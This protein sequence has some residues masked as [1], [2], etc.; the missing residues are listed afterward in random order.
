VNILLLKQRNDL[1]F[2]ADP[3]LH[4]FG[5]GYCTPGSAGG[6]ISL[7]S[8]RL[9]ATRGSAAQRIA[10]QYKGMKSMTSTDTTIE[11]KYC[12]KCGE[13]KPLPKFKLRKGL[14]GPIC[15]VCFKSQR[16]EEG[17]ERDKERDK[18]RAPETRQRRRRWGEHN[19]DKIASYR[20]VRK[21]REKAG[22]NLLCNWFGNQCLAC[23]AKGKLVPDH[24]RPLVL[25]G[26]HDLIN[27]QPLC[28]D[29]NRR[30]GRKRI[31]Y[32][33]RES[34]QAFINHLLAEM[35]L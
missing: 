23:G 17:K 15:S 18:E 30:K 6:I 2:S 13:W 16:S 33:D 31:D 12:R 19:Q 11:G 4:L 21:E 27:L 8:K 10:R 28:E 1:V 7:Q 20:L 3:W 22:W 29:C 14:R 26:I 32:R 5:V 24:V 9:S 34:L 35:L 25:G